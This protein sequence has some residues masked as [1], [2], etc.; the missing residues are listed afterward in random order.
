M[1][2]PTNP[3]QNQD[4]IKELL[5]TVASQ[6]SHDPGFEQFLRDNYDITKLSKFEQIIREHM[7]EG[8]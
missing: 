5:I 2:I 3:P 1:T 4:W 8:E 6:Y 7:E